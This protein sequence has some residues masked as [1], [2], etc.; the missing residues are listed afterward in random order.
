MTGEGETGSGCLNG[1]LGGSCGPTLACPRL[2]DTTLPFRG[3]AGGVVRLRWVQVFIYAQAKRGGL[4]LRSQ[5]VGIWSWFQVAWV[6]LRIVRPPVRTTL[7][8]KSITVR[9]R[10]VA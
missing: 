1:L 9:R 2:L 6:T 5:S 4:R 3:G 8:A 10:V 7:A